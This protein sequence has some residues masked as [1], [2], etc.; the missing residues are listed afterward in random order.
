MPATTWKNVLAASTANN[1]GC[2]DLD[3]TTVETELAAVNASLT[4]LNQPCA[5]TDLGGPFN[6]V[7][8]ILT[9]GNQSLSLCEVLRVIDN[10]DGTFTLHYQNCPFQVTTAATLAQLESCACM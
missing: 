2:R 7:G 8:C 6:L 5:V 4:S 9:D 10:Q 3:L 1:P